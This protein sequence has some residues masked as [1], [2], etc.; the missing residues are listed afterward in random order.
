MGMSC[1]SFSACR[2]KY[3]CQFVLFVVKK[4]FS[5]PCEE[6]SC[7]PLLFIVVPVVVLFFLFR[8]SRGTPCRPAL[9]FFF[10]FPLFSLFVVC[11]R[12]I[13]VVF[14]PQYSTHPTSRLSL[15]K[16]L[17]PC[18]CLWHPIDYD[19]LNPLNKILSA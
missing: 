1:K 17:F 8:A 15:Q 18:S 3:S 16:N 5:E 2:K 12:I 10:L 13:F 6:S 19:S 14:I 4:Y 11:V 7:C 9:P